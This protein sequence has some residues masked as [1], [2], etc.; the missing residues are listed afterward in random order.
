[1]QKLKKD[2]LDEGLES[3]INDKPRS[4]QPKKYE[5]D[6]E[7]EII[8][9]ACSDLPKGH[10]RWTFR[11]LAETLR[12]KEGFESVA[13]ETIRIIL[14]KTQLKLGS[15]KKNVVHTRNQ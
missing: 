14:K 1:M 13:H 2:I 12:E 11:L 3:A 9:L 6:K 7:T 10:K 8:A 4:G 5:I 15:K